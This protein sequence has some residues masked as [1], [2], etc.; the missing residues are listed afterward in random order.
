MTVETGKYTPMTHPP[1]TRDLIMTLTE[2]VGAQN[3]WVR[4]KSAVTLSTPPRR[5][6]QGFKGE[7]KKVRRRRLRKRHLKSKF[8]LFQKFVALIHLRRSVRQMLANLSGVEF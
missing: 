8:A 5:G 3:C 1:L 2:T 4:V 7:V 6:C